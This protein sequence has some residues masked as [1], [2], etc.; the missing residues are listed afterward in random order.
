MASRSFKP[1]SYF[2]RSPT[3]RQRPSY[4]QTSSSSS[5]STTRSLQSEDSYTAP[6]PQSGVNTPTGIEQQ[7]GGPVVGGRSGS[8]T[9]GSPGISKLALSEPALARVSTPGKKRSKPI[10]IELPTR[11]AGATTYTPLSARGDLQGGYFPNHEEHR[12]SYRPHPF[13]DSHGKSINRGSTP[14]SPLHNSSGEDSPTLGAI[15]GPASALSPLSP[16]N[17]AAPAPSVLTMPFGKY[18]PSNYKITAT[19]VT[20][21]AV[22]APPPE[23][24]LPPAAKK[25]KSHNSNRNSDVKRKLQQYQR[26]MIEQAKLASAQSGGE[27]GSHKP[28]S[29][30]LLPLGSPGPITPLELEESLHGGYL[31]AGAL[32]ATGRPART[33]S[34]GTEGSG[35]STLREQEAIDRMI[36][37][38]EE[39]W[40]RATASGHATR[41]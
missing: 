34:M 28:V 20:T 12:S 29:P 8:E 16:F 15:S 35:A 17:N 4:S 13:G 25:A 40:A 26:D 41:V 30:R 38:E 6:F 3:R 32:R 11:S 33:S 31:V 36:E 14:S 23:L 27:V 5:V 19:K 24:S 9:P 37:A 2:T 39:R 1:A 7:T 18:H 22:A 21:T 10:A